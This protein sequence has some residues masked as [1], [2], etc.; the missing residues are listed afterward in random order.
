[1]TVSRAVTNAAD[2]VRTVRLLAVSDEREPAFDNEVNRR[3][4]GAVDGLI[5]AGDLEPGYLAFLADAFHVPL[6]HVRGNHDR[7]GGWAESSDKLPDPMDGSWHDLAGLAVAG[8]SWPLSR[9]AHA[10]HDDGAAWR[11]VAAGYLRLR[12]RRPEIIISHVPPLGIGDAGEDDLYHRGFAAYRWLLKRLK[13]TLWIHG[14]TT[15]ASVREWSLQADGTTVVNVTGAV[16][17]DLIP[18][19]IRQANELP[20]ETTIA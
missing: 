19:A 5:G 20:V 10:I 18:V 1:M 16:L 4:L 3:A 15:P 9:H 8:L 12:R 2:D 11:Q 6:V 17:I 7:G 13:P 14:H